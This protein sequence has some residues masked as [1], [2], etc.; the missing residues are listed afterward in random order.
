MSLLITGFA[1]VEPNQ[2]DEV[3][4][5][6]QSGTLVGWVLLMVKGVAVSLFGVT[7]S[8]QMADQV[9][10]RMRSSRSNSGRPRLRR[11]R[12]SNLQTLPKARV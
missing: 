1:G 4:A 7:T 12:I 6:D 11:K 9:Y 2:N 3:A 5:F 10:P 8:P